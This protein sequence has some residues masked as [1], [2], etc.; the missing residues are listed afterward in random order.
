M[1]AQVGTTLTLPA[2]QSCLHFRDR[3]SLNSSDCLICSASQQVCGMHG[4]EWTHWHRSHWLGVGWIL[5]QS[6]QYTVA[7]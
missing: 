6:C 3:H 7:S 5:M 2:R 4:A 1:R